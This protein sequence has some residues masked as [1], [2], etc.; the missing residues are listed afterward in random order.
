V[1]LPI[2]FLA[3]MFGVYTS[4]IWTL[5]FRALHPI[6]TPPP[7]SGEIPPALQFE[8]PPPLESEPRIE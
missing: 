5:A 3:G 4:N 1:F 8:V 7:V 2:S 6:G